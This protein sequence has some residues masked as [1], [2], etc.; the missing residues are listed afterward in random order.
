MTPVTKCKSLLM[1]G[2]KDCRFLDIVGLQRFL[3][4][5]RDSISI[6]VNN[7]MT[8]VTAVLYQ[9]IGLSVQFLRY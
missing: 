5:S 9:D 1:R 2:S 6:Q 8:S 3:D 4:M 7:L